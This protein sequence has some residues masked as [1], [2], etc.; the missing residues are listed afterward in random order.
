MPAKQILTHLAIWAGVFAFWLL[1]TLDHHPSFMLSML[2]TGI[3]VGCAA[4]AVYA[5]AL[6][7]R[8]RLAS[9]S[10]PRYLPVLLALVVLLGCVAAAAIGSIYDLLWGPDPLRYGFWTNLALDSTGIALHLL[11][12]IAIYRPRRRARVIAESGEAR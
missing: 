9:L 5:H 8:P 1:L 4:A 7:L 11:A 6:L 2:A 12:A 3:M 10:W